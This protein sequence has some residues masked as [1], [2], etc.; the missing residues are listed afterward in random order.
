MVILKTVVHKLTSRRT[1]DDEPACRDESTGKQQ[2]D[3]GESRS[4]VSGLL[5]TRCEG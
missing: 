3:G 2:I 5:E 4:T 1:E